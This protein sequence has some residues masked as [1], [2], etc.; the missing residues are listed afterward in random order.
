MSTYPAVFR[1]PAGSKLAGLVWYLILVPLA[2]A[3]L[4][5][6]L[7]LAFWGLLMAAGIGQ[8]AGII[9]LFVVVS[10]VSVG[11]VALAVEDY[12]RRVDITVTVYPDLLTI[13]QARKAFAVRFD[14][15]EQV[16]I[17]P[18]GLDAVCV[19]ELP[20]GRTIRLPPEAAPFSKVRPVL[21]PALVARLADGLESRLAAGE[22]VTIQES[23][24]DARMRMLHAAAVMVAGALLVLTLQGA[25]AGI[26]LVGRAL[27]HA[28]RGWRGT[29]VHWE[30]TRE[31][32]RAAARVWDFTAPSQTL[33]WFQLQH[34]EVDQAGL[35]LRFADGR[36]VTASPF[37]ENYWP[38][39]VWLTRIREGRGCGTV[40]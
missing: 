15:V 6:A 2:I 21:E 7:W 8:D 17:V 37:A 31:G 23:G 36:T 40:S 4:S 29:K 35:V 27:R 3:A 25:E 34:V 22:A 10:I 38:L 13:H 20:N 39:A 16:R 26:A 14:Q 9:V 28:Q 30:A 33:Y 1:R 19:L 11:V 32:L 18:W 5:V 12:Q 24:F